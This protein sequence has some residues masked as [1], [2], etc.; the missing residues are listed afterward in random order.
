ML[1]IIL[2]SVAGVFFVIGLTMSFL[3]SEENIDMLASSSIWIL[4]AIFVVLVAIL[5]KL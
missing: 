4:S 3:P 5:F 2:L 1:N